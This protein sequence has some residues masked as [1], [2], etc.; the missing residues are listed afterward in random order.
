[1]ELEQA[2]MRRFYPLKWPYENQHI[3]ERILLFLLYDKEL[4]SSFY[5]FFV[6]LSVTWC[7]FAF[8]IQKLNFIFYILEEISI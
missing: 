8:Y 6:V 2:S 4:Q 5:N 3:T 7:H 1:M